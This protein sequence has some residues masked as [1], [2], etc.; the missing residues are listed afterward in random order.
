MAARGTARGEGVP[1]ADAMVST[2]DSRRVGIGRVLTTGILAGALT[3]ASGLGSHDLDS[4][5]YQATA[6]DVA[7]GAGYYTA[8]T[9]NL[10]HPPSS[11]RAVRLPTSTVLLAKLPPA[12]WPVAN[13]VLWWMA[14]LIIVAWGRWWAAACGFLW[15]L[16]A[17]STGTYLY[18]E[19][20]GL[21]FVL[22]GLWAADRGR[23]RQA[24]WWI[25][26]AVAFRELYAVALIAGFV[27][28][29]HR[30]YIVG[31][32]IAGVAYAA[33]VLAVLPH[34]D[35]DGTQAPFSLYSSELSHAWRVL[36]PAGPVSHRLYGLVILAMVVG[37][38]W[39]WLSQHP[40]IGV[41]VGGMMMLSM[42]SGRWYWQTCYGMVLCLAATTNS[43]LRASELPS[44]ALVQPLSSR[45]AQL[46]FD[47]Q[48]E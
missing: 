7:S 12:S 6:R 45:G 23:H 38:A 40:T 9:D 18:Q 13:T 46:S 32:G 14:L 30:R 37:C 47:A 17:V 33:H 42:W 35:P 4:Q 39:R 36:A 44:N 31:L 29:R 15:T 1:L 48:G 2:G 25:L 11:V 21:P 3:I 34:L 22:M 10:V 27:T 5:Y 26:A 8:A 43:W 16:A 28:T 24:M 41:Y 19:I 20:F